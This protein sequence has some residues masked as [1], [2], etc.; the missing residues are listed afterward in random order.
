VGLQ[1]CGGVALP[2][3]AGVCCTAADCGPSSAPG[4][5]FTCQSYTCQVACAAGF[6]MC[7]GQCISASCCNL[8]D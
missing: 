4:T 3:Q 5:T 2:S 6:T 7:K 8:D 1:A